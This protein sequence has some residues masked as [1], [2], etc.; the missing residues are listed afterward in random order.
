MVTDKSTLEIFKEEQ[1]KFLFTKL[2]ALYIF[3]VVLL[4]IPVIRLWYLQIIKGSY[5]NQLSKHNVI[6]KVRLEAVRGQIFDR[7]M[8]LLVSNKPKYDVYFVP[9]DTETPTETLKTLSEICDVDYS[10]LYSSYR[11]GYFS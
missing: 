1:R 9:K 8:V 6:K 2:Q 10:E 5:F 4:L 3:L 11:E 7:N